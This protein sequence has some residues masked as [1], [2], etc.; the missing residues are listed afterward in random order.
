MPLKSLAQTSKSLRIA[1]LIAGVAGL[2]VAVM[3]WQ[4][5]VREIRSAQ[6]DLNRRASTLAHRL[7]PAVSESLKL[8]DSA[9]QSELGPWLDGHRRLLGF[10]VFRPDGRMVAGGKDVSDF[11]EALRGVVARAQAGGEEAIEMLRTEDSY[12][13]VLAYRIRDEGGQTKGVLVG[14][15]DASYLEE[16]MTRGFLRGLFWVFLVMLLLLTS[17]VGLTWI[18]YERPLHRL[19]QWMKQLRM[20]DVSESPPPAVPVRLLSEESE[21]LAASFRA[22][23][24]SAWA[25]SQ[26]AVRQDKIW[27]RERLAAHA[28]S[29]LAGAPLIIVSN[30]EPYMHIVK[31]GEPQ[32]VVPASGLVTALDPVLQA[33]GGLWVAHGAGDADRHT[34]DSMG[35]LTV[36]PSD[37]RY[38]LK[39][40]WLSREEEQG[41]Y[42]GFSNE[43]LWPLCHLTHERPVFRASDWACYV[44]ANRLFADAV[45]DE[46]GPAGALVWAHD[47][48][49]ALLPQELKAARPD[50]EVGLFWHIPWPNAEAF[51]I[52][53]WG[54][55]LLRGMLGAD[56]I[57]FH[58]QQYCNNFLDTVDRMLEARLDW[59]QFAVDLEGHRTLVRPFPISVQDWAERNVPS[60]EELERQLQDLKDRY[61]LHGLAIGVGVER[62]DYTKG[63][64][65]RFRALAR[66]WEKYPEHRKRFS[67]VQLG[68]PSRTHLRRYRDLIAEL[69]SIAEEINWQFQEEEWKPIHFLV[70]HHDPTTVHA[71]LAMATLCVVSP[72]HDG[73][74]LVAKEYVA[75]KREDDGVLILSEFAG[76]AR[77]LTEAILINPYDGEAFADAIH[78]A[79]TLPARERLQRMARLRQTVEENNVYRWAAN[80]LAHV[81]RGKVPLAQGSESRKP[82]ERV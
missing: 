50:L 60:G 45:L 57:G 73:M 18:A 11:S 15:H 64:V 27:T 82:L 72:L 38:T 63:L 4:T 76:A 46:L 42:Y 35:R 55:A 58:L 48:H 78:A 39:R 2:V 19:A 26:E 8:Q 16:R 22:A 29:C 10:A 81:A 75:A 65:E 56:L 44:R 62:M 74:N 34:C 33:C 59:D 53:P 17:A 12:L 30:R 49:L 77:E 1:L 5:V 80:F 9:I 67:F 25:R 68:A 6:E 21:H 31:D 79:L 54:P 23:R 69:E 36:P 43:G 52:C 24:S 51:G 32:V 37:P 28:V 66:L 70:A 13:H 61:K 7:V 3:V 40:V 47:Y 14:L 71:F 20:G 41:Y